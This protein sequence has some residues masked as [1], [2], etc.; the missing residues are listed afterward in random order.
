V[1][2]DRFRSKQIVCP[3][4]ALMSADVRRQVLITVTT[5]HSSPVT[6]IHS[7][8]VTTIHS[9]PVTTIHSSPPF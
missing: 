6:T 3:P 7:S 8:P 9:S 2:G 5:I 1:F 4:F